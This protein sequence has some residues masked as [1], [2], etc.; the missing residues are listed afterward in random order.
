VVESTGDK[1]IPAD[2]PGNGRHCADDRSFSRERGP[3]GDR[4]QFVRFACGLRRLARVMVTLCRCPALV[5]LFTRSLA[6]DSVV[7]PVD[8]S[9]C[10][11][12]AF[13][14]DLGVPMLSVPMFCFA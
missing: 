13:T 4:V 8:R 3:L 14:D 10:F 2:R 6:V 7:P 1:P 11:S 5:A 12:P 9:R